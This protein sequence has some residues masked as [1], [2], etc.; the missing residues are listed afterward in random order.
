MKRRA[1]RRTISNINLYSQVRHTKCHAAVPGVTSATRE[2]LFRHK[3][4]LTSFGGRGAGALIIHSAKNVQAALLCSGTRFP[5]QPTGRF[6]RGQAGSPPL[7]LPCLSVSVSTCLLDASRHCDCRALV[8]VGN[9][10]NLEHVES[11]GERT[12]RRLPVSWVTESTFSSTFQ[13]YFSIF[14]SGSC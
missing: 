10:L 13:F 2:H 8:P 11:Q 6:L 1:V 9:G 3:Q 14:D 4:F 5:A 12:P 7:N